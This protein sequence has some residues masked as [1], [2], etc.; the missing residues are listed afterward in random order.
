[1]DITD[2]GMLATNWQQGV[3]SPLGPPS[4]GQ[5]LA[6]FGL[7]QSMVPEPS[8]AAAATSGLIILTAR[9]RRKKI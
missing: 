7:P 8:A 9:R 4:F 3:G 2:L 5:A 1:V 6:G